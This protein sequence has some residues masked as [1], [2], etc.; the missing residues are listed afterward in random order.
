M[1]GA[2]QREH[3]HKGHGHHR[4]PAL[5]S[6]RWVHSSLAP[7]HVAER[8]GDGLLHQRE[9][10]GKGEAREDGLGRERGDDRGR[11]PE[12]EQQRQCDRSRRRR[13]AA[14]E[15]VRQHGQESARGAVSREG[16]TQCVRRRPCVR[17]RGRASGRGRRR[18]K[19]PWDGQGL[20]RM[21]GDLL[22]NGGK[23]ILIFLGRK[24]S[25]CDLWGVVVCHH[26]YHLADRDGAALP[27]GPPAHQTR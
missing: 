19:R 8:G 15:V 11:I 4:A 17:A 22:T 6:L 20:V 5:R 21:W 18:G 3:H 1:L 13:T 26:D 25:V 12:R 14:G 9:R 7:A 16:P 27:D 10:D 2:H 24:E 23:K